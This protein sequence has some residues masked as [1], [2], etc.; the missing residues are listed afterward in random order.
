MHPG[1][2]DG[3]GERHGQKQ[4]VVERRARCPRISGLIDLESLGTEVFASDARG[5]GHETRAFA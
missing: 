5:M 4:F 1:Q 3:A 2:H